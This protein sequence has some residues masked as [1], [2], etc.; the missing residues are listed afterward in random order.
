MEVFVIV[1]DVDYYVLCR[2]Q[3]C[4]SY[5]LGLLLGTMLLLL[6]I[7]TVAGDNVDDACY[8][9]ALLLFLVPVLCIAVVGDSVVAHAFAGVFS[10]WSCLLT[11]PLLLTFF[12]LPY[13]IF[14][15]V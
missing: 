6:P 15:K 11:L 1:I 10:L 14:F 12:A 8:V 13:L 3:Y 9:P 4:C 7:M 5:M 2:C